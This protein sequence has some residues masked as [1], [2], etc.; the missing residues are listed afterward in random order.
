MA[1][2]GE[3]RAEG[4]GRNGGASRITESWRVAGM[5]P[6][7]GDWDEKEGSEEAEQA[8][9][10]VVLVTAW[11]GG[12]EVKRPRE[13]DSEA[14]AQHWTLSRA[15][16]VGKN[17]PWWRRFRFSRYWLAHE[18]VGTGRFNVDVNMYIVRGQ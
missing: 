1:V 12:Q 8:L 2:G 5:R 6:V 3:R 4:G 11:G 16:A 15:V 14:E 18:V 13:C 17:A 10:S 9:E 7:D